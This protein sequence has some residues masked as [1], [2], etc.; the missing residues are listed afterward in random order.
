MDKINEQKTLL[1]LQKSLLVANLQFTTAE[2]GF[3]IKIIQ[4]YNVSN[5]VN[6]LKFAGVFLGAAISTSFV[7]DYVKDEYRETK[8]QMKYVMGDNYE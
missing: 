3:I 2:I 6:L 7:F 8:K 5:D 4:L 1:N